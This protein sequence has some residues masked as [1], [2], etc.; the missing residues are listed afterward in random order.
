[1]IGYSYDVNPN[2]YKINLEKMIKLQDTGKINTPEWRLASFYTAISLFHSAEDDYLLTNILEKLCQETTLTP[3]ACDDIRATD[4]WKSSIRNLLMSSYLRLGENDNCRENHSHESCLLPLKGKAIHMK[5]Y[6]SEK[7][8]KYIEAE[9]QAVPANIGAKWLLNVAHMTLG[10]YPDGVPKQYLMD[11]SLFASEYDI[12][13]FPN[14]E[15][16]LGLETYTSMGT[17]I[18][19]DFI[20]NDGLKDLFQC[21]QSYNRNVKL[22]KNLGNGTFEDV[23]AD[24]GLIGIDGG[25]NC[26]QADYNNDGHL[27]IFIMRGGWLLLKHVNSILRNNGDG[28]FT[29]VTFKS[30]I[31]SRGATHTMDF[32]DINRDGLLDLFVANEDVPCELWLNKGNDTFVNIANLPIKNC[33]LVKGMV[34]TDYNDDMWPD[35]ML[36][37]YSMKNALLRN[38]GNYSTTESGK[39]SFTD[40][41]S[42]VGLGDPWFS[43]PTTSF[44]ADQDGT[45]DIVVAGHLFEGPDAVCWIYT[46]E[47]YFVNVSL[48]LS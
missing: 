46:N 44:D 25:A 20:G 24:A 7:A 41:T 6:G 27:D 35:I 3:Y 26:R 23:T 13:L 42:E 31:L 32:A 34:F 30:G 2:G 8:I 45:L 12:K 11:P 43:F 28:T 5:P 1:M 48:P 40:V 15:E 16:L 37:R 19:D 4:A 39:W 18:L 9:L 29:D 47:S 10:S 14:V 22:Y 17:G 36:S 33:G 21:S 38:D